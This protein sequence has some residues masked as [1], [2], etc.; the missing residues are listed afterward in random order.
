MDGNKLDDLVTFLG[1]IILLVLV[2]GF[3]TFGMGILLF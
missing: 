1:V 3:G 2:L